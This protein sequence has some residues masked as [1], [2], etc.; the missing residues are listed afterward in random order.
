MECEEY[1]PP[2]CPKRKRMFAA[3][4]E[5]MSEAVADKKRARLSDLQ[6]EVEDARNQMKHLGE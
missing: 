1:I 4:F 2:E 6:Q 5:P 3:A